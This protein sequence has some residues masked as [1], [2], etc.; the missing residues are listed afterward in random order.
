MQSI[1][2]W[3]QTNSQQS[4][5]N[6]P[7]PHSDDL[8]LL[9][10]H[11]LNKNR[12]WLF[13]HSDFQLNETQ[14]KQLNEWVNALT[15]GQPMAYL[16][17]HQMF[18][19]LNLKVN[20]HTLIPRPDT[21]IL[22]ETAVDLLAKNYSGRILDLGTGSGAIALVLAQI[23]PQSQVLAVDQSLEALKVARHNADKYQISNVQFQQSNWFEA[24]PLTE[25]FDLIVSNPPYIAANDEHLHA[26]QHEPINAL[27]ADQNGLGD[28]IRITSKAMDYL[29]DG[30][31]LMFEHGWQQ[32]NQVQNTLSESGF[33]NIDSRKDLAGHDRV[34]FAYKKALNSIN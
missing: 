15:K 14:I 26:L 2:N 29:T 16:T 7:H 4:Q 24:I 3:L 33:K 30:G 13:S 20:Q 25:T 23:Y 34:T 28:Y 8:R 21:E 9:L 32:K 31:L 27:V 22:I 5:K 1:Q 17:G 18:W 11:L 19:D 12:A 10:E 6:K